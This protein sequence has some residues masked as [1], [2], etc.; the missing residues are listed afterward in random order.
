M[1]DPEETRLWLPATVNKKSGLADLVSPHGCVTNLRV[2]G[3][4]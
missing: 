4:V 3:K 2:I 1:I